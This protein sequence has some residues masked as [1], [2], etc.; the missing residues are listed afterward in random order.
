M[1]ERSSILDIIRDKETTFKLKLWGVLRWSP[2]C[3][4]PY[5]RLASFL[6]IIMWTY[7]ANT[8]LF[9]NL[10]HYTYSCFLRHPHRQTERQAF[11]PYFSVSFLSLG[12]PSWELGL[13]KPRQA[14]FLHHFMLDMIDP[15]LLT[16]RLD[17]TILYTSRQLFMY[18]NIVRS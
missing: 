14:I 9:C 11:K 16:I 8:W 7:F 10:T 4:S 5:C 17:G 12:I 18:A 2:Y 13:L 1:H 6:F 15:Y 3:W